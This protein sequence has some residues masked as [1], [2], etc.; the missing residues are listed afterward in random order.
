MVDTILKRK[1]I[2]VPQDN[3]TQKYCV[4]GNTESRKYIPMYFMDLVY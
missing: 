4:K 3:I 1:D 2:L